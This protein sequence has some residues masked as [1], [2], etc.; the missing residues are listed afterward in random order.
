VGESSVCVMFLLAGLGNPG[1]RYAGNRHNVGFLAIDAIAEKYHFPAFTSRHH[2]EVSK[3]RIGSHEVFLLK[4]QTFM[5]RSGVSVGEASR[6]H[7][8]G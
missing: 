7:I 2:G 3:G 6:F 1:A 8:S 4:P 5:N